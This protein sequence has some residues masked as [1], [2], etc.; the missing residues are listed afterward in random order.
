MLKD[1]SVAVRILT[2]IP[3]FMHKV[4]R[5]FHPATGSLELNRTHMK[6]LMV[7][8]LE[9]DPYMTMVCRHMNMEK[10]SLT[11]VIDR[12]LRMNLV[13]R[14]SDP[15]DRR[16]VNLHLTELG[17]SL[18]QANLHRAHRHIQGKLKHLPRDEI[19]RFKNALFVLHETTLK[20]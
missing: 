20:L 5:D 19:E 8:Y 1:E 15:G 17:Q 11:P 16:K 12:L 2:T 9:N 4:F 14:G 3:L 7:I 10:G 13:E 18:V 6:A